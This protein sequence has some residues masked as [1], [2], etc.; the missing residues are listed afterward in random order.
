VGIQTTT[1]HYGLIAWQDP[2]NLI[3]EAVY[4]DLETSPPN[5]ALV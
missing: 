4:S 5:E 3:I 1:T 2:I